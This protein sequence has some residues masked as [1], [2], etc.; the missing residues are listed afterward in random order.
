MTGMAELLCKDV[1]GS[2][3]NPVSWYF[4]YACFLASIP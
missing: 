3:P 4:L 1:L 2:L